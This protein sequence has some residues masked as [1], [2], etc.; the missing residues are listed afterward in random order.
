MCISTV[1]LASSKVNFI[2]NYYNRHIVV[3]N[4]FSSFNMSVCNKLIHTRNM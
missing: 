1:P 2:K 3:Y 4:T